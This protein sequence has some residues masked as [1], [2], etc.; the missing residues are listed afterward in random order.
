MTA[1]LSGTKVDDL[2]FGLHKLEELRHVI[3]FR[4]IVNLDRLSLIERLDLE[5]INHYELKVL[6]AL[7]LPMHAPCIL[8][9]HTQPGTLYVRRAAA[10]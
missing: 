1:R 9:P 10:S 5:D 7:L 4:T 3:M 6:V 2:A 8:L